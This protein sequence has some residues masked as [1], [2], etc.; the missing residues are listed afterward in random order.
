MKHLERALLV[1]VCLEL[2]LGG[3]GRLV[4]FGGITLR[5]ILFSLCMLYFS[6]RIVIDSRLE[7]PIEILK[8]FF[9]FLAIVSFATFVGIING[10]EISMIAG[11]LKPVFYFPMILFFYL[12]I[13]NQ[14]DINLVYELIVISAVLLALGYL[15]LLGMTHS[16][17]IGYATVYEMLSHSG[18]FF[19]RGDDR[20]FLGFFYKG[21][22]F[23]CI[24]LIFISLD[25]NR[26]SRI[27]AVLIFAAI[28]LT[29]TRGFL[30]SLAITAVI[31]WI[32]KTQHKAKTII[33]I[34]T[35]VSAATMALFILTALPEFL[36]KPESDSVR[37]A[38]IRLF[39]GEL[40]IT[41][42]FWGHGFGA[43]IGERDRVEIT[44]LEVLYKQG[45]VG[46]AFWVYFLTWIVKIYRS[47]EKKYRYYAFPFWLATI[48]V[49]IQ[50][51][52]NPFL[53]NSI[54]MSIVLIS[55][56][57]LIRLREVQEMASSSRENRDKLCF[58]HHAASK[59]ML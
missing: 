58:L 8:L 34:L 16:G 27:F 31:G 26:S 35:S 46:L 29:F 47:I 25:K 43:L 20:F 3:A 36:Q 41:N 50:T 19:F 49:F 2:F 12:V 59:P 7:L 51:A 48:F 57:V 42:L 37:I 13:K 15:V 24:G 56:V 39:V 53:T 23:L 6:A 5:M 17:I 1:V 33:I 14:R 22:L 52:T 38:D 32:V 30:A 28:A 10:A 55:M 4:D 54:G 45:L 44:Y 9:A 11:D 40:D 21:F 18:E